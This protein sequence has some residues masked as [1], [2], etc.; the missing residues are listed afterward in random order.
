MSRRER[1]AKVA[2]MRTARGRLDECKRAL[3]R[4]QGRTAFL[5]DTLCAVLAKMGDGGRCRLEL[6]DY[7]RVEKERLMPR[8]HQVADHV[9][10]V[11]EAVEEEEHGEEAQGEVIDLHG[12]SGVA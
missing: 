6:A 5:S 12:G 9:V 2:H 1:R 3:A 11:A 10:I 8:A 7:Q 4:E